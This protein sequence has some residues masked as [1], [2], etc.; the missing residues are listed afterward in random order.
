MPRHRVSDEAKRDRDK[1]K[2]AGDKVIITSDDSFPASDPPS[3]TGVFGSRESSVAAR[4][5][6]GKARQT[7]KRR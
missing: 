7:K 1:M 2:A 5:P 3:W 6:R 4:Q